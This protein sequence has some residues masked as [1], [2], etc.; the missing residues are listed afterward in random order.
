MAL[1]ATP[2]INPASTG[3]VGDGNPYIDA[4]KAATGFLGK[5]AGGIAAGAALYGQYEN[6]NNTIDNTKNTLADL[7]TNIN[8]GTQ[9]QPYGV[10]GSMGQTQATADGLNMT[11]GQTATGIQ[12]QMFGLGQ[13]ELLNSTGS[14]QGRQDE[15]YR[16]MQQSM[17]PEQQRAQMMMQQQAQ[18]QGRGGMTSGMYGGTSEQLAYQKALQEQQSSNWLGAGTQAN[19]EQAAQFARG[20]GLMAEGYKPEEM[21]MNYGNQN[22]QMNQ[23][24]DTRGQQRAGMLAELGLGGLTT[25]TNL[26]NLR[27]KALAD[28]A[29]SQTSNLSAFGNYLDGGTVLNDASDL[30]DTAKKFLS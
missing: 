10:T 27:G 1:G 28:F 3:A 6:L 9:F 13:S 8:S 16:R 19:A 15:V 5:N 30:W 17:A 22:I 24:N 4:A 23:L 25:M 18:A 11:M 12:N 26:E 14:I 7:T 21:L 29:Q 20:Q 2:P